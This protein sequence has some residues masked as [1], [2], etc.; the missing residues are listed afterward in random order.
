MGHPGDL[1]VLVLWGGSFA[2]VRDLPWANVWV[3]PVRPRPGL[4]VVDPSWLDPHE[5]L[6]ILWLATC[7]GAPLGPA[8]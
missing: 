6:R 7:V 8:L 3:A 5:K 2:V 4:L 1:V